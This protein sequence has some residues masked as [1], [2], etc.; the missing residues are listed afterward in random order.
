MAERVSLETWVVSTL[1]LVAVSLV[2]VLAG[3]ASGFLAGSLADVGT[4]PG[5]AVFGYLWLLVVAATKWALADGGLGGGG[6]DGKGDG[7]ATTL[8]SRGG[9]AGFFVGGGFLGGVVLVVGV[10]GV[11]VGNVPPGPVA[12]AL[13][14]GSAVAGVVGSLVGMAC[15]VADLA[16]YRA[17]DA[18]ASK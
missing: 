16:F 3:H 9:V 8:V 11:L 7:G 18:V 14:A 12:I 6:G 2:V 4:L 13:V 10:G 1:N 5:V 17:G 15:V